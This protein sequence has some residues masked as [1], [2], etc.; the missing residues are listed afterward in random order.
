MKEW[1]KWLTAGICCLYPW[2]AGA[3]DV[4]V[5]DVPT[6]TVLEGLARSGNINLVV[7]DSVQGSLTMNLHD[8]TLEEALQAITD[9]QGLYYEQSGPIRTMSGAKSGKG[10]K[11]FHTWSLRHADPAVLKE[12]V[13]AAVPEADVRCHGDTNTL[14]V[15][16]T[17]QVQAAVQSLVKRLDV[18]AR[19][20]DVS[21]EVASVDDSLLKQ[22]GVEWN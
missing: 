1:K 10:V 9:S 3:V 8:V 7:D 19:Q 5:R 4:Q 16:G 2:T 14:V 15:G 11:T 13:Q 22:T 20:V 17:H 18:P 21:V 12:A 6:R